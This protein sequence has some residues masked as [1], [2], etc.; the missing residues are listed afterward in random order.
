MLLVFIPVVHTM[1]KQ[2][3]EIDKIACSEFWK[4][5]D[6]YRQLQNSFYEYITNNNFKLERGMPSN[7]ENLSIEKYKE[8]TNY[9]NT[10]ELLNNIDLELPKTPD[11]KDIKKIMINRDEKIENE[12]IKPKDALIQELYKDNLSLHKELSKQ[13]NLI[14]QAEKFEKEREYELEL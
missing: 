7:K 12:I 2:S 4:A 9:K 14:E 5:K 1:N 10:K 6:S 13:A 3:Q 8:V 11:I